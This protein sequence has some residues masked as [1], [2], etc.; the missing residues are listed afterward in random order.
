M[1]RLQENGVL[2]ENSGS[3][4]ARGRLTSLG[5]AWSHRRVTGYA[6]ALSGDSMKDWW[7]GSGSR[8]YRAF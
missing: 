2:M 3:D 4:R 6:G 7:A 5:R 8:K 1:V